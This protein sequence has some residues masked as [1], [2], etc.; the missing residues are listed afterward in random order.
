MELMITESNIITPMKPSFNPY[1]CNRTTSCGCGYSDVAFRPTRIIGGENVVDGS[2]SMIVSLRFDETEEHSCAGT[3][4]SNSFVLTAAHCVHHFTSTHPINITIDAGITNRSDANRY[5]RNV[6]KIYI[7][8]NYTNWPLFLNNIALLQIDR[9]FY[10]QNNPI[11]AKTCVHRINSSISTHDQ[12]PKN[13]T[14]LVVIGWGTMRLGSFFLSDYLK[15]IQIHAI[16]NQDQICK[17]VSSNDELQF[18]AG[19]YY[20]GKGTQDIFSL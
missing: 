3:L 8:P 10:F 16:D 15:Q 12:H 14:P 1:E 6:E 2:W 13:G 20:G 19:S 5:Q 9:P 7:H 11:L 18:C 17:N 4:L